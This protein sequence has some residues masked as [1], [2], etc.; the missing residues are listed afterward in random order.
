MLIL[1]MNRAQR[2]RGTGPRRHSKRARQMRPESKLPD[3]RPFFACHSGCR[4]LGS[5]IPDTEAADLQSPNT[6]CPSLT[7][8]SPRP[9]QRPLLV[10]QVLL[11]L[12]RCLPD[13]DFPPRPEHAPRG[14]PFPP[15]SAPSCPNCRPHATP[16]QICLLSTY[17]A[18]SSVRGGR[19]R[20]A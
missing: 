9:S 18:H 13:Q 10:S 16:L 3:P 1:Q 11:L 14:T 17:Y 4:Q 20:D 5:I 6:W 2:G 7:P 15:S 8:T 19:G 12:P